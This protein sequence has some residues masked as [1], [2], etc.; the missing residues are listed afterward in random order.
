MIAKQNMTLIY[1]SSND[2][3]MG[4]IANSTLNNGGKVVGINT[5][6]FDYCEQPQHVNYEYICLDTLEARQRALIDKADAFVMFAGGFGTLFEYYHVIN[7]I[8]IGIIEPKPLVVVNIDKCFD[9]IIVSNKKL[10]ELGLASMV[11]FEEVVSSVD[12]IFPA[13]LRSLEKCQN[14]QK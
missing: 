13:I 11:E 9:E 5:A 3:L 4:V 12:E 8:K 2:G 6:Y 1:G 7:L 14:Y 10:G